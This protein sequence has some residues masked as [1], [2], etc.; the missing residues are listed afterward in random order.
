MEEWS[1]D[2][3]VEGLYAHYTKDAKFFKIQSELRVP[4]SEE[5]KETYGVDSKL[6]KRT[7]LHG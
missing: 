3:E 4:C 7:E 1:K 2:P 6:S 5:E